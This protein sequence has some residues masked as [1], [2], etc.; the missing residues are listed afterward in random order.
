MNPKSIALIAMFAISQ[1]MLVGNEP[2][3]SVGGRVLK[4]SNQDQGIDGVEITLYRDKKE[5]CK[6][7]SEGDGSYSISCKAGSTIGTVRYDH[8]DW[9][10]SNVENISGKDNH[11]IYKTLLAKSKSFSPSE[12]QEV[13]AT[14]ERLYELDVENGTVGKHSSTYLSL[15]QSIEQKAPAEL[16]EK[17]RLLRDRYSK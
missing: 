11:K 2:T 5:I 16:K 12:V 15:L 14:L 6:G 8:D 7:Y 10:V 13:V 17:I 9:V 3:C 4:A 1:N